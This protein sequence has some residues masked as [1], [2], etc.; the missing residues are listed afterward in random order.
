MGINGASF[1]V[2]DANGVSHGGSGGGA[3]EGP[4]GKIHLS[5]QVY[6]APGRYT[7]GFTVTSSGGRSAQYGYPN[8]V[9][10]PA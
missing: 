5:T 1:T 4:D 10:Q 6:L 7:V 2:Y 9:G 8:G 3:G